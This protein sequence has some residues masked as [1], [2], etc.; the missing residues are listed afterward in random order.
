MKIFIYKYKFEIALLFL[1]SVYIFYFTLASFLRYENFYTGRFDLGNMDQTVWNTINGRIFEFTNPNGTETI[2]RLSFHADFILILI[3][4]LYLIW[5]SPKMLLLLQTLVLG[6]GAIFV[7]LISNKL[8]KNKNISLIFAFIYLINPAVG[9]TN[10]YDFHPVTLATTFL[11]GSFY[12]LLRKRY[13]FFVVFALLSGLTKEHVWLTVALLGITI[14]L[15]EV[16]ENK[17]KIN[18]LNK[19]QLKNIFLGVIIFI[20]SIFIFYY[21]IWH[22][23]P[24][25]RGGNHFAL[26]YYSEFGVSASDISK[27]IIL[28]PLKTFDT[29]FQKPQLNYLIQLLSPLGFLP[30]ISAFILIFAASDL[31]INLLSSNPALHQ[32]YYQYSSTITPFLFI[33]SIYSVY[34]I[35]KLLPKINI[36]I[37]SLYLIITALISAYFTGPLP[38]SKRGNIDM[39]TKQLANASEI[40]NLLSRIPKEKSVAT[41][42]NLGSHLSRRKDI[43]IIPVGLKD[44]D[45][46]LFLL[47]DWSAQPSLDTQKEMAKNLESN[48]DYVLL[49]KMGDFIAFAKKKN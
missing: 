30:V 47:N 8:L 7:Y 18:S 2:S 28:N 46:V 45:Y 27:N 14:S 9:Y 32:I 24:D 5:E 13:L 33:S 4:P 17:L 3:S 12:F 1:I 23:I 16:I 11:L 6:F 44:A 29:L 31:G 19:T 38:L 43:F 10:L 40:E 37:L 26:E 36:N 48:K 25:A 15:R 20:I 49:S 21:L 39:F 34:F 42:N 41:T 35:K 22:T